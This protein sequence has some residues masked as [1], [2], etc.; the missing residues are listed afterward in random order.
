MI[1][2]GIIQK[3]VV[4]AIWSKGGSARTSEIMEI[5]NLK[6]MQVIIASH[7]L[8]RR[9]LIEII[10]HKKNIKGIY[11]VPP[12]AENEFVLNPQNSPHIDN[13]INTIIQE[14]E[15]NADTDGYA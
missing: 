4:Y 1:Q 5:A 2:K 10:P 12:R 3:K 11:G 6:K 13:K 14:L 15:D 8:K 9:S 7:H